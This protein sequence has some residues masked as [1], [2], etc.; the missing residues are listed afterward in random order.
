M[1]HIDTDTHTHTGSITQNIIQFQDAFVFHSHPLRPSPARAHTHTGIHFYY[2]LLHSIVVFFSLL[3]FCSPFVI[4][5]AHLCISDQE[6]AIIAKPSD[7]K[8]ISINCYT[9]ACEHCYGKLYRAHLHAP[10]LYGVA[11]DGCECALM[12]INTTIISFVLA[13]LQYA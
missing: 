10:K 11:R 12:L 5:S 9:W 7:I 13:D 4:C 6:Y 3:L 1:E 2:I 8:T